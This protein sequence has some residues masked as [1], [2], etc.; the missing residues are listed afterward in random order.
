MGMRKRLLLLCVLLW[1]VL[2]HAG[3]DQAQAAYKKGDYKTAAKEMRK[4]AKRGDARAQVNLGAM[5]SQG[6]GVPR[7]TRLAKHWYLAAANQGDVYGQ[8][9]LAGMYMYG[10][11]KG[12]NNILALKWLILASASGD[13]YALETRKSLSA[14]MKPSEV[15]K[16]QQLAKAWAA[17]HPRKKR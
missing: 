10:D 12:V 17:K 9:N 1:P 5:Y 16:A 11:D 7:S 4:L 13:A 8:T 3:W 14:K 6:Q 15:K 2:V